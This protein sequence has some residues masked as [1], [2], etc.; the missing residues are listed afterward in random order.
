MGLAN[1]FRISRAVHIVAELGI[2]DLLK[3]GPRNAADLA[4]ATD[5]HPRA[6]YRILR[7]L[8]AV[9]VFHEDNDRHFS[10]TEM[11]KCLRSDVPDS[12][13][14]WTR[15]IGRPYVW[16]NWGQ[17]MHATRTGKSVFEHVHGVEAWEYRANH[18]DENLI[19]DRAMAEI[20][21]GVSEGIANGYD[22][23]AF[24]TMVDVGG[25][26]GALLARVLQNCPKLKGVLF[27]QPQVVANAGKLMQNAG[28]QDRCEM[29][30]GSF[31][32]KVPAG[33]DGY[34][35]KAILHDWDD[36]PSIEILKRIRE[37][38]RPNG[39]LL[40]V[41]R[42]LGGPNEDPEAKLSDLHMLVS[43]S[44]LE[45][46]RAEFEE[47]FDASGFKLQKVFP[48]GTRYSVI[49]GSPV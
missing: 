32:D 26:Q 14:D 3:D 2:G 11:G 30:G 33:Y 42:V 48:T 40:V 49:E 27:D 8:A 22:F 6:L 31:F 25:G 45:R 35:M 21:R 34:M 13:L 38:I 18:P 20:S 43:L 44:G 29:V 37:A 39:K 36:E 5:M 41:D 46:T 9:G 28:V 15:Y 10:L 7:T 17:L 4:A 23:C 16:A 12:V 47:L 19:F 24:E 1:A